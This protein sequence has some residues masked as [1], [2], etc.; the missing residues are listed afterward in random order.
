MLARMKR[1]SRR[2]ITLIW[3][4]VVVF[5]IAPVVSMAFASPVGAFSRSFIHVHAYDEPG[6]VHHGHHHH[7]HS[8]HDHDGDHRHHDDGGTNDGHDHDQ[9]KQLLHVHYDACCPSV[10]IPTQSASALPHRLSGRI[11]ILRVEPM[12]GAPPGRLLR[13]PILAS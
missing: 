5:A 11:A 9:G 10:L 1:A 3:A 8:D 6:H 4:M 13:P 12:Q 7:H 2:S